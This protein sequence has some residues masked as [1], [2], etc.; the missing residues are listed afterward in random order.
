MERLVEASEQEVKIDFVLG[1]KCRANVRLKSLSATT[2][3]AF[4]VQTSSPNKFLVNPPSGLIQPLSYATFQVVLKPQSQLPAT[5]PRSPSDRFLVKTAL[6]PASTHPEFTHD[7][8][9]KVAFVGPFLLRHAVAGGD[10]DAVR[11]IIKRQRSILTEFPSRDAESLL[12]VATELSNSDDMVALLVEAGLKTDDA[13]AGLGDVTES[14]WASKGWTDLHV[15]AAFDRTEEI[16]SL[17]RA[18]EERRPLDCRDKEGRTPLHLAASKGNERCARVLAGAGADVNA[19]SKDGR[20]AL[21]RAAA[22]G[23]R[24]MVELLIELGADPT[25]SSMDRGR[26]AIDVARDKGHTEVVN[27]L[28]RGE[29]VLEAARRGDLNH[30]ESL[31]DRDA[32]VSFHDQY[33]LTALHVAAIKGHKDAVMMLVEL[34]SADLEC[35][36]HEGHTPLHLAVEGGHAETVEVLVNRGANVNAESKK[37]ATPLYFARAMGYDDISLFLTE[38]GAAVSSLPSTPSSSL[39]SIL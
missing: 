34:G 1:S 17:V 24:Q 8:K 36:D 25:I 16:L 30:L 26:S 5:F 2:P 37:G 39:S 31:L 4:K 28:Q 38:S 11:N 23:D 13:R 33:G 21:Y 10:L 18:S 20:T 32:S 27:L 19:A 22:N 7:L 3:V 14:R 6:A 12:R 29:A 9:L 35:Q 15:A